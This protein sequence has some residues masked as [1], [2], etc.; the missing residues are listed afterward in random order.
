[1]K[2]IRNKKAIF[3]L[4]GAF[5]S[6]IIFALYLLVC[7]ILLITVVGLNSCE[8]NSNKEAYYNL[9]SSQINANLVLS[10]LLKTPVFIDGIDMTLADLALLTQYDDGY[11]EAFETQLNLIFQNTDYVYTLEIVKIK[12]Q[13]YV[14]ESKNWILKKFKYGDTAEDFFSY[15]DSLVWDYSKVPSTGTLDLINKYGV[16]KSVIELPTQDNDKIVYT[17]R[18]GKIKNET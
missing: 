11:K 18:I 6:I 12:K 7:A 17:L 8:I 4:P 10:N 13:D 14:G 2:I 9:H 5:F 16:A 15:Y 1:M 3:E